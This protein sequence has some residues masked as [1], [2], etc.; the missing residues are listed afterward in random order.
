MNLRLYD[1]LIKWLKEAGYKIDKEKFEISLRSHP[2]Y[3]RLTSITDTF[4]E[5]DIE[6]SAASVPFNVLPNLT[7]PF[8][9]FIKHNYQEQFALIYPSLNADIKVYLGNNQ[10]ITIAQNEL[11]KIWTGTIVAIEKKTN[12]K[13]IELKPYPS[14]LVFSAIAVI[15]AALFTLI[16][17]SLYSF[18]YFVFSLTGVYI[19]STIVSH[20]L[21]YN[22]G[23]VAKFC[24]LGNNTDCDTLLNSKF[25]KLTNNI[26]LSDIGIIY[27]FAQIFISLLLTSFSQS[28]FALLFFLSL[29][30]VPFIGYSIYLQKFIIKKWC[31]LC[32]GVLATLL[33][34][35]IV[36]AFAFKE[37]EP[38]T[39]K[40]I[41]LSLLIICFVILLWSLFLPLLKAAKSARQLTIESLSF[42]RN[43]YLLLPYLQNQSA[44]STNYNFKTIE[45][46]N[47]N[48]LL[49][50]ITVTNPLCNSCIE[51][52][53]LLSELLTK[54]KKLSVQLIFYVP[55]NTTDPRTIIAGHFLSQNNTG[56]AH[57]L[58]TW[59]SNPNLKKYL[60][61][62]GNTISNENVE[63]LSQHKTWCHNNNI[64]T[65][66]TLIINGKRF[67]TFYRPTDI[68]YFIEELLS[69]ST[70]NNVEEVSKQML[71]DVT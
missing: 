4:I 20:Q 9:A 7:E 10:T 65:T 36:A 21:G 56:I 18:L 69:T 16:H 64:Y 1:I 22:T 23:I 25:A 49:K 26:G 68:Q 8:I 15:L 70:T 24:S 47:Q 59:Y 42:R 32:L 35:A 29:L 3:D 63:T 61:Q 51:T 2:E 28:I 50:I 17:Q 27:F 13:K 30:A 44:V 48:G 62:F 6:H 71:V 67:P 34:Q 55:E 40:L 46:G 39:I 43:Y 57:S 54:Y 60:A 19:C 41:V 37:L 52:H 45:L 38:L 66:P 33:A 53:K 11:E 12:A 14:A 58:E 5:F 31:P